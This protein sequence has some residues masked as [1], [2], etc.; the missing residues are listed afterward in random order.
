MHIALK[1]R[2]EHRKGGMTMTVGDGFLLQFLQRF[3][4]YPFEIELHGQDHMIGTGT[5]AFKAIFK[6]DLSKKE[7]LT[8]TS[9]AHPLLLARPTWTEIWRLRAI[10]MRRWII[11]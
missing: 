10:F 3:D 4:A 9:L 6:E 2:L 8:S 11:F 5:P 7:L 1:E